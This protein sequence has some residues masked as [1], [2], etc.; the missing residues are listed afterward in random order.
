MGEFNPELPGFEEYPTIPLCVHHCHQFSPKHVDSFTVFCFVVDLRTWARAGREAVV[1]L[2]VRASRA[3]V[4]QVPVTGTAIQGKAQPLQ[5]HGIAGSPRF[6]G[7]SS[8]KQQ[9]GPAG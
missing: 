1:A 5:Q 4:S 3:M 2:K 9:Q 8:V 7:S 6:C